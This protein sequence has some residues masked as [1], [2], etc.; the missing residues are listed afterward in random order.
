MQLLGL[1]LVFIVVGI[2]FMERELTQVRTFDGHAL[3]IILAGGVAAILISSSSRVAMRS[4]T[5]LGELVPGLSRYTKHTSGT[6]ERFEEIYRLYTG[7]EE[8][9]RF[10]RQ[11]VQ[12]NRYWLR[13]SAAWSV[14]DRRRRCT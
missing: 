7:A 6:A 9:K 8:L 1:V 10:K 2:G 12:M 14:A 11:R 4:L 3:F 13:L 5:V